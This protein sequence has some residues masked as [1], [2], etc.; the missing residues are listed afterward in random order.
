MNASDG[1]AAAMPSKVDLPLTCVRGSAS[2]VDTV[3]GLIDG[4]TDFANEAFVSSTR[5]NVRRQDVVDAYSASVFDEPG[6]TFE[7]SNV[8]LDG[9]NTQKL[10]VFALLG[11]GT[12]SELD[13]PRD[14][15]GIVLR[16][17]ARLLIQ[18]KGPEFTRFEVTEALFLAGEG[19]GK[20]I[21]GSDGKRVEIVRGALRGN[22]EIVEKEGGRVSFRGWAADIRRQAPPENVMIF[23]D[24]KLRH[25][26]PTW[27]DRPDVSRFFKNEGFLRTGF[28][29][30]VPHHVMDQFANSEIRFFAASSDNVATELYYFDGYPWLAPA[31]P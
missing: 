21:A 14:W 12:A 27:L 13:Y 8:T 22:V 18:E 20:F 24:G 23:V 16:K 3:I 26:G 29:Y 1:C 19:E 10:R 9:P 17:G 6:F 25:A 2:F 7:L 5:A 11:D 4:S 31:P 28:R 30:N 15:D